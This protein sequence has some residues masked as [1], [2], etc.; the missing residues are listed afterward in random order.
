MMRRMPAQPKPVPEESATGAIGEAYHDIRQVIRVSGVNLNFR[1][2]AGFPHFFPLM[3]SAM[4]GVAERTPFEAA[5]GRVR[6]EAVRLVSALPPLDVAQHVALGESQRYQLHAALDLY[7]YVNPKLLLFTA[8]LAQALVRPAVGAGR[9]PDGPRLP[10]GVPPRMYPMEMLD[11]RPNDRRLRATFV[12]IK[13]TMRLTSVN[14]DY[15]T[16]ALWPDYLAASWRA[17][18]PLV[19]TAAYAESAARLGA[20]AGA[21]AEAFLDQVT[22]DRRQVQRTGED[23]NAIANTTDRFL[24][25]LPPLILNVTLLS[26]DWHPVSR[27]MESPFPAGGRS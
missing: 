19:A 2:W 4:R 17:L 9:L 5:A 7:H 15:R 12:D 23:I 13:R 25:L 22:L 10:R 1:T 14:S 8:V 20:A 21:E 11:E 6:A 27:L 3:W 18:K 16:L 26:G 24:Q